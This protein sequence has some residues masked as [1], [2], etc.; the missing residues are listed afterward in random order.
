MCLA[1]HGV[2]REFLSVKREFCYYA[3]AELVENLLEL[4]SSNC[5]Y[6]LLSKVPEPV[7]W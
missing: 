1:S 3:H 7:M 2:A 4:R 6:E 5:A